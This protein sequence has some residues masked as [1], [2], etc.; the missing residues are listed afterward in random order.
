MKILSEVKN[1]QR[2]PTDLVFMIMSLIIFTLFAI[3]AST[4]EV[5]QL[6]KDIFNLINGISFN[7]GLPLTIVMYSATIYGVLVFAALAF[8]FKKKR[9]SLD[10]LLAGGFA[11]VFTQI[12]KIIVARERPVAILQPILRETSAIG[13]GFPSGHAAVITAMAVV[14][15]PYLKKTYRKYVW[16][17]VLLI[18]LGRIYLGVHFPTD[19]IGGFFLGLF[20]GFS[21]RLIM[22]AK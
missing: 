12:I 14:L 13:F 19:V 5:T 7:I 8:L 18:A 16:L 11:S 6:E 9:L 15:T 10:L 17:F 20:V 1:I 2:R 22:K 3:F 21:L 4:V